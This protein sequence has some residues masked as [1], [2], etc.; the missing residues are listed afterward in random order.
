MVR[1]TVLPPYR[2][3]FAILPHRCGGKLTFPLCRSCMETQL[4][5][6]LRQR[7]H[8]CPHTEKERTLTG[9]WC[10]PKLQ[11]AMAKGYVIVKVHEVWHFSNQRGD[12]FKGY[13]NTFLKIK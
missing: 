9:T 2:L 6:P 8:C 11:A 13:I 7:T 3:H 1:C 4:P 5:L 12:L 10:T